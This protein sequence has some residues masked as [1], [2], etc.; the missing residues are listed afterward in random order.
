MPWKGRGRE[1][2]LVP[3]IEFRNVRKVFG[4]GVVALEEFSL[5]I[6]SPT[7]VVLVGPSGC[8]KT[9]LLRLI[10][11][12]ERPTSGEIVLGGERLD[13]LEAR[14]RDV[15]MVFQNYALYPHMT[16]REN[17]S[18]GLRIRKFPRAVIAEKVAEVGSSL[19]IAHLL[20]RRPA[21]LSGGQRQRVALGRAVIREPKVFLFDEPLSNLDARLRDEMRYLIKRLYQ[22]LRT[23][24]LYVTHDQVEA[25]TI[26]EILVVLREGRIHQVGTPDECYRRPRDTFV[27]SFLGS[28]PMNLVQASYDRGSRSLYR[29]NRAKWT[30][31]AE[32]VERVERSETPD[33]IVGVRPEHLDPGPGTGEGLHLHGRVT[34]EETLGHEIL[35][36]IDVD[37]EEIIVRGRS[38]LNDGGERVSVWA[39]VESLHVFSKAT[40]ER[41][42]ATRGDGVSG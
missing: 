15:A 1:R 2:A 31:P 36:H 9:T 4:D 17:L 38:R 18:F 8:G 16:V 40:G 29:A 34:L 5:E 10:A 13:T 27:A 41:I 28:P 19:E 14:K 33:L 24:M 23:T 12:L 37:G 42:D 21:E 3:H 22:R 32:L 35:T 30:V 6:P 25:M 11:G 39:P 20:D 26:G 7:L